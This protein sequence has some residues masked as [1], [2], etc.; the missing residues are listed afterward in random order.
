MLLSVAVYYV[1][2]LLICHKVFFYQFFYGK[3]VMKMDNYVGATLA[4]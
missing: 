1:A 4:Q 3:A 2:S